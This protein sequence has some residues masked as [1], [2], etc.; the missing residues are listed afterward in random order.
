MEVRVG[1]QIAFLC[2][3]ECQQK[4]I[5]AK[6]WQS[7]QARIAAAQGVCPIMEKAVDAEM[8]STV[9][10]GVPI[11][12]CCPP[13][14]EKIQTEPEQNLRKVTT[15]YAEFVARE[16]QATSDRLHRLAQG[17]CPVS[18]QQLATSDA[19]VKV[20]VGEE[21][22]FLCCQECV[23]KKINAELWQ[24]SRANLARAQGICPIMEKA[25]DASMESTVVNGRRIFVC[26]PPCIEK[27]D[28]EADRFVEKLDQQIRKNLDDRQKNG[29][30]LV[31]VSICIR[32][33]FHFAVA[34]CLT[35]VSLREIL[36]V[37]RDRNVRFATAKLR[38][39]DL[40][41]RPVSRSRCPDQPRALDQF[42][43]SGCRN[44]FAAILFAAIPI[45]RILAGGPIAKMAPEASGVS[46]P[47][48]RVELA[49][50]LHSYAP[51]RQGWVAK[52]HLPGPL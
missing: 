49:R 8:E 43:A 30:R 35:L 20:Q 51:S 9:V 21:H 25:V 24:Q 42:G 16:R 32:A 45:E 52:C 31:G 3:A 44:R 46:R 5:D 38:Q 12:V 19:P 36:R 1:E 39:L 13:C 23:G 26:C 40:T 18:G 17:I 7:I 22:A 34:S 41:R 50:G 6:H 37:S 10:D 15:A 27:I 33:R 28:A 29:W 4:K 11:F 48:C 47:G 14:I 2:C